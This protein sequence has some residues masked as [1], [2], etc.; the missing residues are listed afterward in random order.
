MKIVKILI[1]T[2]VNTLNKVYDYVVPE[3]LESL[4]S[5]GKRVSVSFG[6]SKELEEGIIVKIEEKTSEDLKNMKY[7]MNIHILMKKG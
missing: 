1:N 3:Y 5:I 7:K 6:K 4:I 2:S